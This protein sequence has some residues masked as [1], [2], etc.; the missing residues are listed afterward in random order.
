MPFTTIMLLEAFSRVWLPPLLFWNGNLCF[1]IKFMPI[2]LL[3]GPVSGQASTT[4]DLLCLGAETLHVTAGV[5]L[6][7]L[8][9]VARTLSLLLLYDDW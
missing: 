5:S 2:T 4:K 3:V 9:Q 8:S 6:K 7:F 1:C